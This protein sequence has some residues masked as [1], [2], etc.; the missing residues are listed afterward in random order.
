MISLKYLYI[1]FSTTQ[2]LTNIYKKKKMEKVNRYVTDS[3]FV[4]RP[5]LC[6][7]KRKEKG[8]IPRDRTVY[9]LTPS[10]ITHG[11][12]DNVSGMDCKYFVKAE[13]NKDHNIT[14]KTKDDKEKSFH[15]RFFPTWTRI[16]DYSLVPPPLQAMNSIS[17]SRVR[18]TPINLG[19]I[20][21]EHPY[22]NN[23]NINTKLPK[24]ED[25]HT[26]E[27]EREA[28]NMLTLT[29]RLRTVQAVNLPRDRRDQPPAA[30]C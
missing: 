1:K 5:I 11:R 27:S 19:S 20:H 26:R 14:R 12:Q 13:K 23:G 7:H 18:E 4:Q 30:R 17:M 10:T 2:W 15:Q 28:R 29:R 25:A 6:L 21:P 9:S 3:D 22:N 16:N 8:Q 24:N